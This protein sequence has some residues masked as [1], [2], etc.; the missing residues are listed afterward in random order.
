MIR[1]LGVKTQLVA[2]LVGIVALLG[3]FAVVVW[4]A[5]GSIAVA[6]SGMGRGKDVV[7]DISA[8]PLTVLEAELTVLQLQDARAE[9]VPGLLAK[10]T[11]LKS[12]YDFQFEFWSKEPLDVDL[13]KSLFGEQKQTAD[14]FWRLALGDFV[15]AVEQ[16]DMAR[17]KV[18]AADMQPT[19]QAHRAAA[20]GTLNVAQRYANAQL[21]S[22]NT[23]ARNGR[24]LVLGLSV[25]GALLAALMM[26]LLIREIMRRLGGEPLMMLEVANRI[27]QGDLTVPV[28]G[29]NKQAGSL[30]CAISEMQGALRGTIAH[31]R[32]VAV[33]LSEA[34]GVLADN[35]RNVS[36]SSAMQSE[37]AATMAASME[38]VSV[39]ISHVA[40][41]ASSARIMADEAGS[42]ASSGSAQVQGT[43]REIRKI[44]A[45]WRHRVR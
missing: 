7:S 29:A 37:A 27:A 17:A 31:S 18:L 10:L 1:T 41:S 25:G 39:S 44:S 22:L 35:A 24:W 4:V 15:K 13:H 11:E 36:H 38:E 33:R 32:D 2:M 6:A 12:T 8:P 21:D 16:G 34:A 42:A 20:E 23:T 5:T 45:P 28:H 19:Y 14:A 26:A 3:I 30:L 9:D 40:D 43:I